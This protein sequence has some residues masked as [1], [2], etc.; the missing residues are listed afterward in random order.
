M[1]IMMMMMLMMVMVMAHN[2][3]I[4]LL[5]LLKTK[6]KLQP[7]DSPPPFNSRQKDERSRKEGN[8]FM[9]VNVGV[10]PTQVSFLFYA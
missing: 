7:I 9:N 10:D 8:A 3:P 4:M 2:Q 5:L 1:M 6:N